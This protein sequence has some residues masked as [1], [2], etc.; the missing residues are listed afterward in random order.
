MMRQ[1]RE[2]TKWIMGLTALAFVGLMVFEWGMDLSGRSSAQLSG[3]E[4]GRVNGQPITYEEY[5]QIFGNL[6]Q[7][8]QQMLGGQTISNAMSRQI[9][10]AAFDQLVMQKLI[11]QELQRRN[12]DAS[13]T[14]VRQAARYLPPPEI[15]SDTMFWTDGQFDLNKYHQFLASPALGPENLLRLERYYRESIPRSKLYFRT[16]AGTYVTD[17]E[18][19][20][21]WR[22]TR[23][24]V[25]VS[26]LMFDPSA[27][28]PAE[29][30]TVSDAEIAAYYRSNRNDF[31]RPARAKVKYIVIDRTPTPADSAAVLERVQ[32]VRAEI[33]GG[34]DFAQVAERESADSVS[35][36]EGG[37]LEVRKGQTVARFDSIAFSQPTGQISQPI[38]TQ[39]GYHIIRVESRAGDST[40]VV[41]HVLIPME[42]TE[43]SENAIFELADSVETLSERMKLDEVGRTLGLEVRESDMVP[44]FAM[45]PG[46][47]QAEDADDWVFNEGVVGELSELFE[48]PSAYYMV[49]MLE[50]QEER[51]LTLEEASPTIRESITSQKR[52][53]RAQERARAAAERLR[54]GASIAEVAASSGATAGEAGPFTRGDFVPELGRFT[55]VIGT[56]FGLKPGATSGVI[57]SDLKIFIVRVDNRTDAERAVWEQQ[58]EQQRQRVVQNLTDQRWQQ[59]LQALRESADIVDNRDE[60]LNPRGLVTAVP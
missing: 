39:Y 53:E 5:N 58:K 40:A 38:L 55:P 13:E 60:V 9:G 22:D 44:G 36:R 29:G 23:D 46:V 35:A 47:P 14:E 25:K 20:R 54:A 1:M 26:Y 43:E 18:L 56:A 30:I 34:A 42:R 10:N 33:V 16:T 49:E 7:Q 3:G 51:T 24:A 4:I 28:V 57:V 11:A 59:F 6:H 12:I 50:R 31:L 41:R 37:R 32:A 17:N 52:I 21:M 19:W 8:Q 2:N 45:L 15:T 27:V 48:T